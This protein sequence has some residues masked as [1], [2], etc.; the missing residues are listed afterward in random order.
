[1]SDSRSRKPVFHNYYIDDDYDD[2]MAVLPNIIKEA[3]RKASEVLEPTIHEKRAVMEVIKN[4]IRE[5]G[6]KVYG[7][8]ALN[9]VLKKKNPADAIYSDEK[10]SDIEFYSPT[11]VPD[12]VELCNLLYEKG[13][14]YVQG[15]E[16]QHEETYSIFV[17]F[18][19]YC[20]I[21]Y[22]PKRIYYG[23]KTI[24]IDGINYTDP[25]FM[26]IDYL[27]MINDP[28][29]AAEQRWEKAFNRMFKLLKNYPLEYFDKSIKI[30]KPSEETRNYL[31]KIKNDFLQTNEAQKTLLISG[32]EAYN[33]F[34]RHAMKDRN[35]EQMARTARDP[36]DLEGMVCN[37]P[38]LDFVSVNYI[39]NVIALYNYIRGIVANPADVTLEEY[40]PLFQFTNR[41]VAIKYRDTPLAYVYE[42]DGYCIP[43]IKTTRGYMYVSFQYL[44]MFML[45]A[46]F[47]AHL[48][49][50]REMYFNYGI[51]ISNLVDARNV[52][53]KANNLSV[54]NNS[55][56]GEFRVACVGSTMSYKRVNFLR[57]IEKKKKGK[58]H[59]F[60]YSPESFFAQD[61]ET[62]AK[63]DPTKHH[64]RNTA[65]NKVTKPQNMI[66]I[67]DATGNISKESAK[68]TDIDSDN[69]PEADVKPETDS[70]A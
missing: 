55:V 60:L 70:T 24:E 8:T 22:V 53:L 40:F 23:I 26:L 33:F 17:N 5:K 7:G 56:F 31:A 14:K 65:G 9:E 16:A 3:A 28:L 49:K 34:I 39:D 36:S 12:L 11:P 21:T 52:Y 66:F 1:M 10:F 47:R 6:R 68:N 32:F 27:R 63:F 25:H 57:A 30:A 19:L 29:N 13:Y 2:V 67:I 62:Q 42:A 15:K 54:I 20:D 18:E 4:Y 38:F 48:D 45:I 61:K 46:K 51:A 41:S 43:N 37:V 69:E 58:G 64:F 35:V 44:L 59:S 50:N